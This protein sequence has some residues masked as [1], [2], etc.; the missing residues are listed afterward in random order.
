MEIYFKES[1]RGSVVVLLRP[2]ANILKF[3]IIV[4]ATL[5]WLE[6][7]GFKIHTILAGLGI[8]GLAVA[9]AAQK[10]IENLIAGITLYISAPVK[11]GDLCRF[12]G[13]IGFIEEIGLRYTRI[14]TI[15]RTLLN[16]ANSLF[17]DMKLENLSKRDEI[18][19]KTVIRLRYTTT[20][21]QIRYILIEIRKLFYSHPKVDPKGARVRFVNFTTDSIELKVHVYIKSTVYAEFLGITEDINLQMMDIIGKSG[22]EFAVPEHLV[23]VQR[24]AKSETD[25]AKEAESQVARWKTNQ[26]LFFPEFPEEKIEELHDTLSFPPEGA[27]SQES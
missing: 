3:L 18:L 5:L 15:P 14:R 27:P 20:P 13:D 2:F 16:I 7:L 21:D 17:V 11:T 24:K 12:N 8:G 26:E 23:S 4:V 19:Y 6:N 10:S 9:L 25:T 22:A 1:G